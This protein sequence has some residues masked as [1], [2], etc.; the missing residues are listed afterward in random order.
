MDAALRDQ[1]RLGRWAERLKGD[2]DA[3]KK[4]LEADGDRVKS[5]EER[6][7]Q[8]QAK[9]YAQGD[10]NIGRVGGQREVEEVMVADVHLA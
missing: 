9:G 8:C 4:K 1:G 6:A 3:A 2:R 10:G 5:A 7:A